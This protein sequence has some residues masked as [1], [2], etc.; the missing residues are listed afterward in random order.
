MNIKSRIEKIEA[1]IGTKAGAVLLNEP[2]A[3]AT[4]GEHSEFREQVEDGKRQ[5]LTVIVVRADESWPRIPGVTYVADR[6]NGLLAQL[7]ETPAEGFESA[8]DK[9]LFAARG[10]TLPVVANISEADRE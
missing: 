10:T 3:E 8:L 5:G 9:A 1:K 7:A 6:F 4:D 2:A